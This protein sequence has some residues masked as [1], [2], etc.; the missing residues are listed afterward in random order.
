MLSVWIDI[1][2]FAFT[3]VWHEGESNYV[4]WFCLVVLRASEDCSFDDG[5]NGGGDEVDGNKDESNEDEFLVLSWR[6][7][8]LL[9]G[10]FDVLL[11]SISLPLSDSD[12]DLEF[13]SCCTW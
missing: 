13:L 7:I 8:D 11:W 1:M 12:I 10:V 2:E 9:D 3:G 6:W 5:D 4:V